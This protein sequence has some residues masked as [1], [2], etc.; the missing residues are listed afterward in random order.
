M[1]FMRMRSPR[2]APPVFLLEGSTETT[3]SCLSGKS[4]KKRRTSSSTKEDFPAPPVPVMPSTGIAFLVPASRSAFKSVA[5]S[6]GKFSAALM[7]W[8]MAG[9]FL[10]SIWAR[11]SSAF[12]ALAL[13]TA[14]SHFSMRSLIMPCRPIERPSSG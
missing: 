12:S 1:A 4:S 9:T 7:Q 14:K 3:A 11:V 6:S 10:F 13:P 2:S 5:F 8:A